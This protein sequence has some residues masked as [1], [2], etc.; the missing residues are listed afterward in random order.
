MNEI[1]PLQEEGV[2]VGSNTPVGRLV[3]LY[4][5]LLKQLDEIEKEQAAALEPY[6]TGKQT[7]ETEIMRV[8]DEERL[9]NA[10]TPLGTVFRNTRYTAS[11]SDPKA[12]MDYVVES[13]SWGLLDRKA[14]TT[15]VRALLQEQPAFDLA[16]IGCNLSAKI[17][18]GHRSASKSKSDRLP[19]T[20][21]V[22]LQDDV[23]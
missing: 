2:A 18:L 21:P 5:S 23:S 6:I 20:A 22:L 8:L 11:L 7:L 15:G 9:Q 10:K 4:F 17:T 1:K 13:K 3:E 16:A 12:F 14:N 19:D